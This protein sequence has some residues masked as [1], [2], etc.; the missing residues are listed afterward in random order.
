[1]DTNKIRVIAFYL[2]Q[3]HPTPENDRWWGKG[4]TEWTNVGKAKP[5]FKGHYQPKVPADLGYYDLRVPETRIEQAEMA[6]AYGIEGFCY[7]HYW[8]GNGRELLKRPFE[9]VLKSGKPDFPFCLGWANHSWEDKQFSKD[10]THRM[11]MEQ[12]Y[13][14]DEDYI[15]HFHSV[16]PAFKDHRYIRVEGKPVFLVYSA[17]ELPDAP[18]FIA[19]W[20]KLAAENGLKG[21]HF[22][23]HTANIEDIEPM[24][25]MGFDAVNLVRLFH[26]FK[27]DYSLAERV[28]LK[29]MKLFFKQGQAVEY[30]RAAKYFSGKEDLREDCYPTII[31]NWDHS[32]RSGR[33]AHILINSTPE[34]FEKHVRT[35]FAHVKDKPE[36]HRIVFLKSWNEWAEGNYMEPDLKYGK[37][38]LEALR[39]AITDFSN[40][41][42]L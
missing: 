20:Q 37:G 24:K 35:A 23:G 16:L 1:M 30:S 40:K 5:L 36:E 27:R 39:R 19:L 34:K 32:P 26:F 12:L 28:R 18:H 8:F 9:E 3:F 15:R 4:F 6:K 10:G 7:W 41:E 11:L 29:I 17:F 14:G 22:I 13:P 31:P 33:K 25:E 2:P 21:I 42:Q 38:Y